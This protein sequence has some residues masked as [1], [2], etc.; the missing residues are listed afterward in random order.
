MKKL[1]LLILFFLILFISYEAFSQENLT[2]PEWVYY[3]RGN[4][5]LH[6]KKYGPALA[7]YKK[8][9]RKYENK[10]SNDVKNSQYLPD[11][12]LKISQ[13]YFIEGLYDAS[14]F[15]A[16]IAIK[17]SELFQIQDRVFSALYLEAKNYHSLN[18][19]DK[20]IKIYKKII[21]KDNNWNRYKVLS[22]SE[23]PDFIFSKEKRSKFGPAYYN[24]G[25]IKYS[26]KNYENAIVYL[27]MAFL[28]M[29]K[30]D[31]TS[32]LLKKCYESIGM[33][34]MIKYIDNMI[35]KLP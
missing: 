20:A 7:E 31:T 29:Y 16:D 10:N 26:N 17:N 30:L 12:C 1:L 23:M 35:N 21:N 13:I 28:Y 5:Y 15:Y 6:E 33:N 27:K 24:L 22:F 19:I 11:I 8:A 4:R 9:L 25:R 3:I 18:R 14:L 32:K 34:Y 2:E